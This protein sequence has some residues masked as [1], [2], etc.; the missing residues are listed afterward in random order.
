MP[1]NSHLLVAFQAS[2]TGK[3]GLLA[4]LSP[5]P[6]SSTLHFWKHLAYSDKVTEEVSLGTR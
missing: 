1:E 4:Y 2:H 5:S 3:E 6:P